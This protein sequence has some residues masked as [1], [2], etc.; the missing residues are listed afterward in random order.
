MSPKPTGHV[1]RTALGADLII[2]R[3]FRAAIEDVW[4]SITHP[5]STARWIGTWSGEPGEGNTVR[6]QMGFEQGAPT[7]NVLI[8]TC[9]PPERLVVSARDDH[10]EWHLELTLTHAAGTTELTFVQHLADP[11]LAG[12]VGPGWEY[13]LDM[14]VA[15]RSGQPRPEFSDYYPGQRDYYLGKSES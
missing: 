3:Q 11:S 15:A 10:G 12:D 9:K 7:S 1:Q 14:L 13:Y 4:Q 2:K 5:E 8:E 6:L